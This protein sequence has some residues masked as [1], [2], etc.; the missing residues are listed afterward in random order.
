MCL[1]PADAVVGAGQLSA[2]RL[3]LVAVDR[4]NVGVGDRFSIQGIGCGEARK[5]DLLVSRDLK[6]ARS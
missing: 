4:I 3:V 5:G 1:G 2:G 6:L